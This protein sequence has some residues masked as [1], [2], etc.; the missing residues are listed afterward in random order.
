MKKTQKM[1]RSKLQLLVLT[2]IVTVFLASGVAVNASSTLNDLMGKAPDVN[3]VVSPDTASNSYES[4]K[5][6]EDQM[7]NQAKQT[8][9]AKASQGITGVATYGVGVGKSPQEAVANMK[10]NQKSIAFGAG[11]SGEGKVGAEGDSS[12]RLGDGGS[13]PDGKEAG[14]DKL[15]EEASN[16]DASGAGADGLSG[17]DS[18]DTST[19]G[20]M[21]A[22]LG[23]LTMILALLLSMLKSLFGNK[24]D[25][26][27]SAETIKPEEAKKTNELDKKVPE[28][29]VDTKIKNDETKTVTDKDDETA[30]G[31]K[32]KETKY[33]SAE[34]NETKNVESN[35]VTENAADTKKTDKQ[36]IVDDIKKEMEKLVPIFAKIKL[37]I[38]K[39]KDIKDVAVAD[40][41]DVP[42]EDKKDVVVSTKNVVNN[43]V[44]NDVT[45]VVAPAAAAPVAP[46][47]DSEL[48]LM[49][50]E[51]VKVI[52]QIVLVVKELQDKIK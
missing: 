17:I 47:I 4:S 44:S 35:K 19:K 52:E 1:N 6:L 36:L 26:K 28:T 11:A 7:A 16:S 30:L 51:L 15:G 48:E 23:L 24:K 29:E 39:L 10:E 43:T 21:K 31:A 22:L 50:K 33:V 12:R 20:I 5:G 27:A 9:N 37:D 18:K 42:V 34:T 41:K 49:M 8:A 40:A 45:K 32:S 38:E 25:E 14:A 2:L 46:V 3:S 13:N